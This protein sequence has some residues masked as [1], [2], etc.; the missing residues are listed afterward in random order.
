[1]QF[2]LFFVRKWKVISMLVSENYIILEVCFKSKICVRGSSNR[3][4]TP[5]V[6][7]SNFS[8][9]VQMQK[10]PQMKN[11]FDSCGGKNRIFWGSASKAKFALRYF[12][13]NFHF[14]ISDNQFSQNPQIKNNFED[15][16]RYLA[17]E[18][19]TKSKKYWCWMSGSLKHFLGGF[20]YFQELK[21]FKMK[22]R[23]EDWIFEGGEKSWF[24]RGS[25]S[26]NPGSWQ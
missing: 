12:K 10:T 17:A 11:N 24:Y 5:Y 15:Y 20:V 18:I 22:E 7:T 8:F 26:S 21:F 25:S 3:S 13:S 16:G 2:S 6:W 19:S 9:F 14:L 4:F 23:E 1:M